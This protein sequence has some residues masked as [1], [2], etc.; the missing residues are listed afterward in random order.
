ML[1]ATTGGG[2]VLGWC[3]ARCW[4]LLPANRAEIPVDVLIQFL[5]TFAVWIVAEK[6]GVSSIITVV[7]YTMTIARQSPRMSARRRISPYAVWDVAVFVLNVLAFVL[8]GLQLKSILGRVDGEWRLYL[9]VVASVCAV[10]ILVRIA[11]M[12]VFNVVITWKNRVFGEGSGRL[13]LRPTV[14]GSIVVSWCGMRG[15][16]TLA[17][18][19]ALPEDFVQRDLIV[20]SAFWV[21]LCT[22]AL[23]GLTLR[24]LMQSLN[25]PEDLSVEEEI[26]L[27]RQ[28]TARA[29]MQVLETN[30]ADKT[31]AGRLLHREYTARAAGGTETSADAGTIAELQAQAVA[32]QRQSLYGLR[33]DGTIGD[34]AYHVVEEELDILELTA[35]PRFRT[36]DATE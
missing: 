5:G 21:V 15:I 10:V 33:Q 1:I 32:A 12:T 17:T 29:T 19:L 16:V 27:A 7:V 18:A 24:P 8:I 14:K 31:E 25:L 30:A 35:D 20:F 28:A 6:L 9:G 34:D 11:W 2:A 26:R 23:Q 4:R 36:L 22:L 3:L 13:P